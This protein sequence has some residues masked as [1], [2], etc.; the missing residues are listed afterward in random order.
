M[1]WPRPYERREEIAKVEQQLRVPKAPLAGC[2][3]S[4]VRTQE[5]RRCD[6]MLALSSRTGFERAPPTVV[7]REKL[8]RSLTVDL[9]SKADLTLNSINLCHCVRTNP[10]SK[11]GDL[12]PRYTCHH[13]LSWTRGHYSSFPDSSASRRKHAKKQPNPVLTTSYR[14]FSNQHLGFSSDFHSLNTLFRF[15]TVKSATTA[16]TPFSDNC[17]PLT[18]N[19]SFLSTSL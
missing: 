18:T 16:F 17:I 13:S 11:Q 9:A 14:D 5:Q 12:L 6:K 4:A 8:V 2:T 15:A 19:S 10:I 7:L 1:E 3:T